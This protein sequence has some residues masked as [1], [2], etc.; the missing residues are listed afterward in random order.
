[1]S[2]TNLFVKRCH[3]QAQEAVS[4][5]SYDAQQGI[6]GNVA[7]ARF[8]QVLIAA[9]SVTAACGIRAGDLKENIIVDFDE[10]YDLPS[11][12]V[13][14]IGEAVIRLTFH[15]E[16]CKKILHLV[17]FDQIEHRRGVLGSFLNSGRL[18]VGDSFSVTDRRLE[19]IPYAM[20]ERIQWILKKQGVSGAASDLAHQIGLPATAAKLISRM[21]LRRDSVPAA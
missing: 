7:C 15:C 17:N 2:V 14:T 3:G 1:M 9:Q 5:F 11:G 10:L 16:P 19:A 13:V 4:V 8:R 21:M 6:H 12:A 20:H 18:S